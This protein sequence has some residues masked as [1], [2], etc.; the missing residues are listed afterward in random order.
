MAS[1]AAAGEYVPVNVGFQLGVP[2]SS[3]MEY[4]PVNVGFQL[5]VPSSSAMEYA[6]LGDVLSGS[7]TGWGIPL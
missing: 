4:I 7:Y 3:A 5:G 1:S 6:Y 2:S